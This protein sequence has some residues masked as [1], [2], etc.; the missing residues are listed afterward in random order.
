MLIQAG[1]NDLKYL[2]EFYKHINFQI[3]SWKFIDK[4]SEFC[5]NNVTVFRTVKQT[6]CGFTF[7]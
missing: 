5:Y 1:P 7:I 6:L 3:F 4:S 2:F